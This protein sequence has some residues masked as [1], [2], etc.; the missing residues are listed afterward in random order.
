MIRSPIA[1]TGS[2]YRLLSQLLPLFPE[3]IDVFY[4]VFCG[5]CTVSLNTNANKHVCNDILTPLIDLYNYLKNSNNAIQEIKNA[6]ETYNIGNNKNRD[7]YS[8][9]RDDYNKTKNPL[10]LL[11]LS[12]LSFNHALRFNND[13]EFNMPFGNPIKKDS[14]IKEKQNQLKHFIERCKTFEFKNMNF[15]DLIKSSEIH[16]DDFVYLDPP[17]LITSAP[18]LITLT[19]L[20][21]K[22]C[23]GNW[24]INQEH[25]LLELCDFLNS[26]NVKFGI[27]NVLRHKGKTNDILLNWSKKYN[28]RKLNM[29]YNWGGNDKITDD[30]TDEVYICNYETPNALEEW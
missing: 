13:G 17:Y 18:Y 19:N 14:F 28:V 7:I 21:D 27:S 8:K 26:N 16:E 30:L 24:N 4:D 15:H 25:K 20:D 6:F 3:K 22:R 11:I 12:F 1:Y 10:L 9:L 23:F 2:K 29:Q 5:S